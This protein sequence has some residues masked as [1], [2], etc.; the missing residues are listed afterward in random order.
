MKPGDSGKGPTPKMPEWPDRD[1]MDFS[2]SLTVVD[3]SGIAD[4]DTVGYSEDDESWAPPHE[5][6]LSVQTGMSLLSPYPSQSRSATSPHPSRTLPSA[7]VLDPDMVNEQAR[8]REPFLV[9]AAAEYG[10][11]DGD[12]DSAFSQRNKK[13]RVNDPALGNK[14]TCGKCKTPNDGMK[15]QCAKC[16]VRHVP[17][18]AVFGW[19][20]AAFARSFEDKWKCTDC[21]TS[22]DNQLVTCAACEVPRVGSNGGGD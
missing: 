16:G 20:N 9:T 13:R 15:S 5:A 17:H 18:V 8:R 2:N 10:N 11:D 4:D 12:G 1:A 14:W 7:S 19:G 21:T 22:N 6:V 3:E